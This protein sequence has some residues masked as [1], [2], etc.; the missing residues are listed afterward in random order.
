MDDGRLGLLGFNNMIPVRD[1]VLITFDIAEEPDADYSALLQK[2]A[3][4]CNRNKSEIFG[5][6]ARTYYD[7]VN[8]KT[9]FLRQSAATLK[10]S[11]RPA[12]NLI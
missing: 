5:K 3:Y 4:F 11:K 2:Q 10:N 12:S 1:D 9:N 7:V 8:G 6:A